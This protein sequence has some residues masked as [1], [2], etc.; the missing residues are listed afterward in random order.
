MKHY[1]VYVQET[2]TKAYHVN[3]ET[4]EEA[5]DKYFLEG[6]VFPLSNTVKDRKIIEVEISSEKENE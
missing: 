6:V 2:I 3:A 1:K 5:K 4:E